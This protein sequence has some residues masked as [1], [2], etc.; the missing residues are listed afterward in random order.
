[1]GLKPNDPMAGNDG[2]SVKVIAGDKTIIAY[3]QNPDSRV[4][5]SANVA[6]S[7]AACRLH[8]PPGGWRI[9]WSDPRSGQWHANPERQEISGGYT[10]DFK[11]P[12]P[13][14]AVLLLTMP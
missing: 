9:R 3:L 4:P 5:E 6:E 11:S 13:G 8:L 1:V 10:R 7:S 2:H 14:D 12:F